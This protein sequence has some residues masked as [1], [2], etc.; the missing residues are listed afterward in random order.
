MLLAGCDTND[1][2]KSLVRHKNY[3]FT[4]SEGSFWVS[5]NGKRV[6]LQKKVLCS[7]IKIVAFPIN[8]G[9]VRIIGPGEKTFGDSW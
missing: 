2:N 9:H 1:R 8:C 3:R 5:E 6:V 4:E 7:L